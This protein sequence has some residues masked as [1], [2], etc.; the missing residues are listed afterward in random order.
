VSS[1]LLALVLALG[2]ILAFETVIGTQ[3][4]E[5]AQEVPRYTSSVE[6]KVETLQSHTLGRIT[7]VWLGGDTGG[8]EARVITLS[9]HVASGRK[10]YNSKVTAPA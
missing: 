5:L 8:I 6:Q 3:L 7:P 9:Y 4:V 2:I 1:A 10:G